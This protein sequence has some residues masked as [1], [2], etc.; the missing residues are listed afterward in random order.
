[1]ANNQNKIPESGFIPEAELKNLPEQ[2]SATPEA[3]VAPIPETTENLELKNKT[4]AE[5]EGFLDETIESLKQKLRGQKK[6]PTHIPM[7]RDKITVEVEHIMEEGL[8]DAYRELTPVQQ[9]Q[10]KIKGE[11][12]AWK[13]RELLR[14]THVKV[15][16]IFELLIEWLKM[17][18]GI[19]RF[20]LEQEAKIKTD[21]IIA[22]HEKNKH[23]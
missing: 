11:E 12:T 22:L 5:N 8:K 17:L 21:K 14:A 2:K 7:V 23:H 9:Q 10:F 1:M 16:K 19:N 13:I 4:G 20:F 15:K 6:K 3:F 18:P